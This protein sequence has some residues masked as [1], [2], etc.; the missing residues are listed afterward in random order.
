MAALANYRF[1]MK[2][3]LAVTLISLTTLSVAS[4]QTTM[5]QST[6]DRINFS[7]LSVPTNGG[8]ILYGFDGNPGKLLGTVYLD[9]VWQAGFVRFY[10]KIA[11]KTDSLAGVPIRLDLQQQE[12]EVRSADKSVKVAKAPMIRY[13]LVNN[14]AGGVSEFINVREFRGEADNLPGF[15]EVIATGPVQLLRHHHIT[16]KKGSYNPALN[17]GS[18]DDELI[19]KATW[20]VVK[21]KKAEKF[22][23]GKKALLELMADK[24]PQIEAFLKEKKPDLKS[25]SGLASVFAY[26]ATL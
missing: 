17:V 3:Y 2:K 6:R 14:N 4:G 5:Y 11:P 9:S 25:D 13:F 23:A 26:Y 8:S 19:K 20:Y 24:Q 10:G 21:D 15:F 7:G 1:I 18:K 22:T 16:V 12:V